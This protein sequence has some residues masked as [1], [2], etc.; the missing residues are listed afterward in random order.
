MPAQISIDEEQFVR[1]IKETPKEYWPNLLRLIRLFR[2]SVM[3][4]PAEASFQQGWQE[5]ITGETHPVSELWEDIDESSEKRC[6]AIHWWSK[7]V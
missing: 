5:S 2:E 4:M 1:E 3:L 7:A 6:Q